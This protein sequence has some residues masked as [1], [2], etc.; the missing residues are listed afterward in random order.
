MPGAPGLTG[1]YVPA[2]HFS[3]HKSLGGLADSHIAEDKVLSFPAQC[4]AGFWL[5][6]RAV[7]ALARPQKQWSIIWH[8]QDLLAAQQ[9]Q[10]DQP[11]MAGCWTSVADGGQALGHNWRVCK[12]Y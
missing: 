11:M 7:L 9:A 4:R 8:R 3:L 10:D 12:I 1:D 6:L 5:A 2:Q